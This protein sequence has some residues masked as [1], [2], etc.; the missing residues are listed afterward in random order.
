[1]FLKFSRASK[2]TGDPRSSERVDARR[3]R[4]GSVGQGT[5]RPEISNRTARVVQ[6]VESRGTLLIFHVKS[7]RL[8]LIFLRK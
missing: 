6:T 5:R 2:E 8:L 7:F 3:H 4:S 1:M